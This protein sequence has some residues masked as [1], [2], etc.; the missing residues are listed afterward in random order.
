MDFRLTE[1]QKQIKALVKEFCQREVDQKRMTEI[2]RKNDAAKTME[3]IRANYPWDLLEKAHKAGLRTI[4]L[5]TKYGGPGPDTDPNMA[6]AIAL[7]EAGYSGGYVA[8]ILLGLGFEHQSLRV[9]PYVTEKEREATF[10]KLLKY[11]KGMTCGTI[12]EPGGIFGS[13]GTDIHLPYDEGGSQIL[14]VTARKDGK[15]WVINGDKM[16]SNNGAV[17]T[18]ANVLV[19]TKEGPISESASSFR[20]RTDTPGVTRT[21]NKLIFTDFGGNC[22]Y[23][24]DNVRVP[25]SA[26]TGL[27]H[28]GCKSML[29]IFQYKWQVRSH[30]VGLLQRFYEHMRDY[31]KQRVAGGRPI[32]Q[33]SST[34]AKLGDLAMQLEAL[35]ALQ[36]RVAFETDQMEKALVKGGVTLAP[37]SN[38]YWYAIFLDLLKK[39]SW[40]FCE[41]AH[42]IYG[43]IA[44]SEDLP[45]D[46]FLR[47]NLMFRG[48]AF[49]PEMELMRACW[50]YDTR[51]YY[52]TYQG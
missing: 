34:A 35:R 9:N 12:T 19:R 41:A 33:H 39:V 18:V 47:Y 43:S 52:E 49:P 42:D 32:I 40:R 24:Y 44:T 17:A 4:G 26:L 15:G 22:Q 48:A 45:L 21:L 31:A 25:E 50:D 38:L 11:T 7:E 6:M 14:K 1:E 51:Y 46:T 37:A 8:F 28:Q 36:Y 13:G 23:H 16:F 20:V 29:F 3:E 2:L 27:L 30:G 10:P 5:P